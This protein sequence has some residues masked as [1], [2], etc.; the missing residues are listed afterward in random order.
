[1]EAV[2]APHER[3]P[4]TELDPGPA[5]A[6]RS[7]PPPSGWQS[8]GP[9]RRFIPDRL[10]AMGGMGELRRYRDAAL[11]RDVV[12]KT[13]RGDQQSNE[14]ARQRF[15]REAR[16]Q[17]SLQHPCIVPVYDIANIDR[18]DVHFTMAHVAGQ[19]LHQVL[20]DLRERAAGTEQP[21]SRRRLLEAF[22][23]VCLAVAFAHE[24]G[25]VHR[26]LKPENVMLGDYGEVYILDWGV[27]K[28]D[29]GEGR[30]SIAGDRPS[31]VDVQSLPRLDEE[32]PD[33]DDEGPAELTAV[34]ATLGTLEYMPPEQYLASGRPDERSDVYA[35]GAM[36]YEILSLRWFRDAKNRNDLVR[37]VWRETYR[38]LERPAPPGVSAE[39]DAIW[40]KATA[41]RPANRFQSAR[42]LHD[43]IVGHLDA[44]REREHIREI[45]LGHARAA[46]LEVDSADGSGDAEARRRRALLSLGVALA[47]D[48]TQA[49]S[50]ETLVSRLIDEPARPAVDS[51]PPAPPRT[52][53]LRALAPSMIACGASLVV[54][55]ADRA[56]GGEHGRTLLGSLV[57]VA[58]VAVSLAAIVIAAVRARAPSVSPVTDPPAPE[59]AAAAPDTPPPSKALAPASPKAPHTPGK[60]TT[61]DGKTPSR[62]RRVLVVDDDPMML[63]II[64]AVLS[65]DM[66][67]VTCTSGEK[68]LNVL[69]MQDFHVV[70]AD[71]QMPGMDGLSVLD[72]AARARPHAGRVL[73]TG[74]SEYARPEEREGYHVL[75]KPFDP[76]HLLSLVGKIAR[77]S[78]DRRSATPTSARPVTDAAQ[79]TV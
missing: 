40:R 53:T 78:E 76:A 24:R 2:T 77:A 13:I 17:A 70:C 71:Y 52:S 16:I 49:E 74:S 54:L 29:E 12:V 64:S 38:P 37:L 21:L 7:E 72:S 5:K 42:E 60:T 44:E 11:G 3:K 48:P 50:L 10:I 69:Q 66:D 46:A 31:L 51:L 43:A 35:L 18:N 65:P 22:C 45:A 79:N 25:V 56:A 63:K 68:A 26:D 62:R 47:M 33:D 28:R 4:E 14:T 67:V 32:S 8:Q 57:P 23:R 75:T 1:M 27:A 36:L 73:V 61:Q 41:L 58:L 34:G 30:R 59:P 15:V 6:L 9:A 20:E 39:L 55:I 19:T